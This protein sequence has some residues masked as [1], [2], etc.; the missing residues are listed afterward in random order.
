MYDNKMWYI[1]TINIMYYNKYICYLS[2]SL[3][4]HTHTFIHTVDSSYLRV[5]PP[6]EQPT[7]DQKYWGLGVSFSGRA[8]AP[9]FNPPDHTHTHTHTKH[10]IQ[11][12]KSSVLSMYRIFFCQHSLNNILQQL[13]SLCLHYVGHYKAVWSWCKVYKRM[14]RLYSICH[15]M[16]GLMHWG[17]FGVFR[18]F[19]NQSF[20]DTKSQQSMFCFPQERIHGF[21]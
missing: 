7:K 21:C 13:F 3:S 6:Q 12:K 10:N 20:P 8:Q 1:V 15:S 14:Y 2:L 11:G 5:L 18:G 4:I 16:Q 19:L 9:G 17:S